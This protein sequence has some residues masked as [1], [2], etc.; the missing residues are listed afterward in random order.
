M[1]RYLLNLLTAL[2]LLLCV[3]VAALWVRSYSVSDGIRW[4]RMDS[5]TT[6]VWWDVYSAG[7]TAGVGRSTFMFPRELPAD[8]IEEWS[9]QGVRVLSFR[10]TPSTTVLANLIVGWIEDGFTDRRRVESTTLQVPY[11][12]LMG[13]ACAM[14]ARRWFTSRRRS[15]RLAKGRCP[16]CGYDATGNVSGVCPECGGANDGNT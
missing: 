16:A 11:W 1:K 12:M 2:S 7:G 6:I 14:P 10:T 15:R 4:G 3:A 13:A 5:P 9:R 8:E